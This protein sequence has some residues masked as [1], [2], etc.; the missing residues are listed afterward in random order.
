MSRK[1][2]T[3]KGEW[4]RRTVVF[5]ALRNWWKSTTP[6]AEQ[7]LLPGMEPPP[8]D[9][10]TAFTAKAFIAVVVHEARPDGTVVFA[11]EYAEAVYSVSVKVHK[12]Y[13]A[14][15]TR[16]GVLVV[17]K[18]PAPNRPA[19]YS[20]QVP[21]WLAHFVPD[22]V[23]RYPQGTA[24]TNQR[25]TPGVPRGGVTRYPQGSNAVPPGHPTKR[26]KNHAQ[27]ASAGAAHDGGG[28]ADDDA[29][30][31]D[32]APPPPASKSN[33]SRPKS[34]TNDAPTP[35]PP[36]AA[37]VLA[38]DDRDPDDG[39]T[40]GGRPTTIRNPRRDV[41]ARPPGWEQQQRQLDDDARAEAMAALARLADP[42]PEGDTE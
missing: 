33:G 40:Y 24:S 8:T 7:L 18:H 2:R 38:S 17:E 12:R 41:R 5:H 42:N 19:V 32:G 39:F 11:R 30:D 6:Y 26:S 1:P 3:P 22:A 21:D 14:Y 27:R 34:K 37:D 9:P 23:T 28:P 10:R 29:A 35:T 36:D 13:M 25:G 4:H 20:L 31:A 16:R 15:W